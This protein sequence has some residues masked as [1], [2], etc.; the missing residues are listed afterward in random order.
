[1]E[2][3]GL[4]RPQVGQGVSLV[5]LRAEG[6][7]VIGGRLLHDRGRGLV[8]E[9]DGQVICVRGTRVIVVYSVAED[10]YTIRG[11]V[12]EV[13]TPARFYV[14][15]TT[16]P[17]QM[18]KREHLRAQIALRCAL[19]RVGTPPEPLAIT[20]LE[21]SGSGFLWHGHSD[22]SPG[23]RVQLFLDVPGKGVLELAAEVVRSDSRGAVAGRFVD[24]APETR[25]AVLRLVFQ[26]TYEELGLQD[27]EP[28]GETSGVF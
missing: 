7:S 21:L 19:A 28:Q 12:A 4:P 11:S 13:L 10:L 14:L 18:E 20:R 3:K 16:G 2:S 25:D 22:A 26:R 5:V 6:P 23:D 17:R 1:M 15:P 24:L 8:V 27:E 9:T